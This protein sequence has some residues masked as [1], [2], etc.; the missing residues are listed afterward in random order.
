MTGTP[1]GGPHRT[2][3]DILRARARDNPDQIAYTY[4]RYDSGDETGRA[5]AASTMTFGRLDH[6]V[7]TTAAA[8]LAARPATGRALL[9]H[10]QSLEFLV[11]FFACVRAGVVAVPTAV[12]I[13]RRGAQ[14]LR[15]IVADADIRTVLT[16]SG[17]AAAER[18][19]DNG[20]TV[21]RTDAPPALDST[22]VPERFPT[23]TAL[24]Q[25]TSGSTSDPK[26]VVVT[27]ANLLHNYGIIADSFG[28]SASSTVVT[29]LPHF[30]DM[31][32][33]CLLHAVYSGLH[34]VFFSPTQFLDRPAR[35]LHAISAFSATTSGGP[36]FA[37]ALAAHVPPAELAGVDLS[38]WTVAF[39]GSEPIR[40]ATIR[41]FTETHRTRGFDGRA[42]LPCFGLAESTLMVTTQTRDTVPT[43]LTLDRARLERDQAV[44][45]AE[46]VE[47]VGCGIPRGQRVSIVAPSGRELPENQIGEIWVS[48]ASVG[49]GYFGRPDESEAVFAARLADG[50]PE[51]FL[52]TGDLGFLRAGELFVTGREKDLI[53]VRGAN[54]YPHDIEG[55]AEAA[56]PDL[57]PGRSIAFGEATDTGESLV[58]VAE[59]RR[60]ATSLPEVARAIHRSVGQAHGISPRTVVLVPTGTVPTTTSGKRRRAACRDLHR[61]G[62][63]TALHV[64]TTPDAIPAVAGDTL[65]TW[66][67]DYLAALGNGPVQPEDGTAAYFDS[68]AALA[69]CGELESTWGCRIGVGETL[70]TD[71]VGELVALVLA[72]GETPETASAAAEP[73]DGFP[74]SRAQESVWYLDQRAKSRSAW[75]ISRIFRAR[76]PLDE[77]SLAG[78]FDTL[79][80]RHPALRT[81]VVDGDPTRQVVRPPAAGLLR[82]WP[83]PVD[84]GDL[85]P[86]KEIDVRRG[87]LIAADL[88]A[89]HDGEH[90]LVI[91]VHH[92]AADLWSS[93]HLLSEL[94]V[95][96]DG[97]DLP[98]A[99]ATTYQDYVQRAS[100]P[101]SAVDAG[102]AAMDL[103]P[104]ND[105]TAAG[106]GTVS[107]HFRVEAKTHHALER[108]ARGNGA[109]P[110]MAYLAI[111]HLTMSQYAQRDDLIV[112][113]P[114]SARSGADLMDVVGCFM[115]PT[116]VAL[117]ADRQRSFL[118]LLDHVRGR[119]LHSLAGTGPHTLPR[120]WDR[121]GTPE[122]FDAVLLWQQALPGTRSDI[123]ALAVAEPGTLA[124]VAGLDW[125]L[126]P[127]DLAAPR[128]K[129]EMSLSP[130]EG[131]VLGLLVCDR[132]YFA[133]EGAD[134]LAQ[135]F[136][137]VLDGVLGAPDTPLAAVLA[138]APGH[139][140]RAR[141]WGTPPEQ[142]PAHRWPTLHELARHW[143]ESTPEQ[144]AVRWRDE[145]ITYAELWRRAMAGADVLRSRTA[146]DDAV[147][148]VALRDG[149]ALV[150]TLLAVLAA[151]GTFLCLDPDG[152]IERSRGL[153]AESR[154]A[155]AIVDDSIPHAM[156]NG[157]GIQMVHC[158]HS[159]ALHASTTDRDT[160]DVRADATTPA[161]VAY[162]SGSTGAP[163]GVV[164]THGSFTQFL[165]WQSQV[166]DLRP[167]RTIAHWAST[168]YDA[169]Y[170]E[171][172]GALCFGATLWMAPKTVRHDPRA[173]LSELANA[174]VDVLQTVPTFLRQL[175][176]EIDD[177]VPPL[178]HIFCAGEVL[179]PDLAALTRKLL[180]D[181]T[182]T[183]LYGPTEAVLATCHE[184]Q[185]ADLTK[186]AI[187]LGRPITGRRLELLDET[188]RPVPIGVLGEICL[189]S[190]TLASGYLHRPSLTARAF[191]PASG[192]DGKRMYRT[193]DLARWTATGELLFA[194]R[195]DD[196]VKIRGM[197][198]EIGEVEAVLLTHPRIARC[199][200][201][202]RGDGPT[203][204]LEAHVVS[205]GLAADQ[206]QRYLRARLPTHMIPSRIRFTATLP[207]TRT[208]KVDR[209]G[210]PE[211]LAPQREPTSGRPPANGTEAGLARL[212]RSLLGIDLV[213]PEDDFFA[214]GGQSIDAMR[215]SNRVRSAFAIEL[216]LTAIFDAPALGDYASVVH[217]ARLAAALAS[218][219]FARRL[220]YVRNL[221]D[222]ELDAA[223]DQ[224]DP[225]SD[226]RTE[227]GP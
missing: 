131:E 128:F 113:S 167:G 7:S 106:T 64:L 88:F 155:T 163:K 94:G 77:A 182:L 150:S 120:E 171:I 196:Q 214:L 126:E 11:S 67:Y 143:A 208:G 156:V 178:T 212:W 6:R 43:V 161:F 217:G 72:S 56:H 101:A 141:H 186:Q 42:M 157:L 1:S 28:L 127:D 38:S 86:L 9:L 76:G 222:A 121:R 204:R 146:V 215:L 2:L 22:S 197:R 97:G 45:A 57:V 61:A 179:P 174:R 74:L 154:C 55:T 18:L 210:L 181:T 39:T 59:A 92:L 81:V 71:T 162:T 10:P 12:P 219:G 119:V 20:M 32:L 115:R 62:E 201:R 47:V 172:F 109:T 133:A 63:L 35:W 125:R 200:V 25:Y 107:A 98:P 112:G 169:A 89:T 175:L 185:D 117:T 218:D 209:A 33:T 90:V 36:D 170:C 216:P 138:P 29:W 139:L 187:P 73:A 26:G 30:H 70:G 134:L 176:A 51:R 153:L 177:T 159:G 205:D 108:L 194:G 223:L 145:Q 144:V 199:A 93:H 168:T 48:G 203:I 227:N 147:T 122:I 152:P 53:I 19:A 130:H 24:L 136:Q 110:Y 54:Y 225:E 49:A 114:V 78:A 50:S 84:A 118:E 102:S 21:L 132:G 124:R 27:H 192:E 52:R 173:L 99:P 190:D 158:R 16:Q 207:T 137:A 13:G 5:Y 23:D 198:V 60:S 68:L 151:G 195:K 140:E 37:Y 105:H 87:P 116:A 3:D 211:V 34:T 96:L 164:H 79:V 188:L 202:P 40:A 221:D 31:G 65:E 226:H 220:A 224:L 82:V 46:G 41:D 75:T 44:D 160:R 91:R 149:P 183:N 100:E 123:A 69:F 193:G 191:L 142:A 85:P 14:R 148:A 17:S 103:V 180:P 80:A 83:D 8:L 111:F 58:V 15:S 189:I 104:R 129:I 4:L 213:H 165:H 166:F 66:L 95:L 184:V 135:Q 206:L